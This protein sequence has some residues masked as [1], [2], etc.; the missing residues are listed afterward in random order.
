[1]SGSARFPTPNAPA[2]SHA[3]RGGA[4]G[5]GRVHREAGFWAFFSHLEKARLSVITLPVLTYIREAIG[6]I[7]QPD[8]MSGDIVPVVATTE[9]TETGAAMFQLISHGMVSSTDAAHLVE[10]GLA[11]SDWINIEL[12]TPKPEAFELIAL[13]S[14]GTELADQLAQRL[15][16]IAGVCEAL[17][18]Q[19]STNLPDKQWV[20]TRET[21]WDQFANLRASIAINWL[22]DVSAGSPLSPEPLQPKPSPTVKQTKSR[23]R[24]NPNLPRLDLSTSAEKSVY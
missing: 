19:N 6:M 4:A 9:L 2:T 21:L 7:D 18:V 10:K 17:Q 20:M 16:P 3:R 8:Q 15:V 11:I 1:M 5:C 13:T 23:N 24:I 12:G 14:E 22:S